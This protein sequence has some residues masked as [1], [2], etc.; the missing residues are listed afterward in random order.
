MARW[1]PRPSPPR[2]W[3]RRAWPR[4]GS[5]SGV[6]LLAGANLEALAVAAATGARFV[7]VEAFAYA[8]V[9]DE[10]LLQASAGPLARA[11]RSLGAD[12]AFWADVRKK[13]ASHALT[14]DLDL[15]EL[16]R[17]HVFCGA[18]ALIVTGQATGMPTDPEDVARARAGGVP[19][20]VGSGV[21]ASSAGALAA[22]ADALIVGT[23]LKHG[24]DWRAPVDVARV[25]AVRAAMADASG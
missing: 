4:S 18:D 12:V 9:A 20:A 6:Q 13:H 17:G 22:Q 7:R 10:G 25:R 19:V 21:D 5:R 3:L 16:A 11:R 1:R 2:P 23:A 15:A 14:A 8:H 24:G